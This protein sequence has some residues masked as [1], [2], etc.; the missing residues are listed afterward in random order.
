MTEG[1]SGSVKEQ[2]TQIHLSS[3]AD[4]QGLS[5]S[6]QIPYPSRM[7]TDKAVSSTYL[8]FLELRRMNLGSDFQQYLSWGHPQ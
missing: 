3:Q 7:K 8:V 2:V 6:H 1:V 5:T 4:S